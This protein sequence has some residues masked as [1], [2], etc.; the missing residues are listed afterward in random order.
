MGMGM[1]KTRGCPKRFAPQPRP[2]AF[3]L[4]NGWSPLCGLFSLYWRVIFQQR[5][6]EN[7]G[8]F[9]TFTGKIERLET[10]RLRFFDISR[11]PRTSRSHVTRAFPS[12]LRFKVHTFVR[13]DHVPEVSDLPQGF[14][15]PK[16]SKS[17]AYKWEDIQLF[18]TLLL[19]DYEILF[20]PD[21]D[22]WSEITRIMVDQ[23]T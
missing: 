7:G 1:P 3:P 9:Y 17:E 19:I 18:R 11:E 13:L 12:G 22:Q 8:S 10:V 2:R 23:W 4:K 6:R 14:L 16:T 15:H 20:N 5:K 21:Q